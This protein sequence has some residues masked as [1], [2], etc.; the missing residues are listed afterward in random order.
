VRN[1]YDAASA[2]R[3]CSAESALGLCAD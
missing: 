1:Q 3:E 2:C